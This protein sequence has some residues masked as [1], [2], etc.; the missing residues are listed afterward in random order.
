[1]NKLLLTSVLLSTMLTACGG[2]GGGDGKGNTD[3]SGLSSYFTVTNE[4][5]LAAYHNSVGVTA[6]AWSN[7][8]N[9]GATSEYHIRGWNVNPELGIYI[10]IKLNDVQFAEEAADLIEDHLGYQIFDRTSIADIPNEDIEMGIVFVAGTA[11]GASGTPDPNSCGNVSSEIGGRSMN[12][13]WYGQN[14]DGVIDSKLYVNI[15]NGLSGGGCTVDRELVFHELLHA[16]GLS[17]HN[18]AFADNIRKK[19]FINSQVMTLLH[20]VIQLPIMT[21]IGRD[22]AELSSQN[23]VFEFPFGYDSDRE[24]ETLDHLRCESEAS[25][26]SFGAPVRGTAGCED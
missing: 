7:A 22:E 1:M 21:Y 5:V 12:Y 23:V 2:G 8:G 25:A 6:G 14:Q 15:G 11:V 4:T 9:F 3:D 16:V 17:N 18:E 19:Y 26:E 13:G 24:S 10:P 20:N